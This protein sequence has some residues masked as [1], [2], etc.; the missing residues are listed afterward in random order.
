M[1]IVPFWLHFVAVFEAKQYKTWVGFK[2]PRFIGNAHKKEKNSIQNLIYFIIFSA[3]LF[4]FNNNFWA[5]QAKRFASVKANKIK[6]E[7]N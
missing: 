7:K 1:K 6:C 2:G 5:K 4:P 3:I